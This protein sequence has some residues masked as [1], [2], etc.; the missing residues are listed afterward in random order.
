MSF[1]E[2]K[3]AVPLEPLVNVVN[4]PNPIEKVKTY[5]TFATQTGPSLRFYNNR[6]STNFRNKSNPLTLVNPSD[7]TITPT[8]YKEVPPPKE[9]ETAVA[10]T[11]KEKPTPAENMMKNMGYEE[12]KG[13]GKDLQGKVEPIADE[14]NPNTII[15]AIVKDTP[16]LTM[17]DTAALTGLN[18]LST[19]IRTTGIDASEI[20]DPLTD[21]TNTI[22]QGG[23]L[24][25][26]AINKADA[27]A[28]LSSGN[29]GD[30]MAGKELLYDSSARTS[31][32]LIGG[33]L[34][35][36][37]GPL[38]TLTGSVLGYALSNNQ[39]RFF[40]SSGGDL[41]PGST[42]TNTY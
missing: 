22:T 33:Q 6:L 39:Q 18:P 26:D 10:G 21:I 12:G 7:R 8:K 36:L 28:D 2:V 11:S 42:Y 20:A 30:A 37:L 14:S 4:G 19:A 27:N 41:I 25:L 34:G 35:S 9:E 40:H 3:P 17:A 32:A 15:D 13:L 31:G 24:A 5:A 29:L 16:D 1:S 23:A 38:G